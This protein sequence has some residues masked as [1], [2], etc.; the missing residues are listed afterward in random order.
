[1][2]LFL[3]IVRKALESTLINAM[4]CDMSKYKLLK[5]LNLQLSMIDLNRN[6]ILLMTILLCGY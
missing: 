6:I 3:T 5:E 2:F 1:M 4:K